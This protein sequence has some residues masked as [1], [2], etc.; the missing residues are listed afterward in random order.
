MAYADHATGEKPLET[1]IDFDPEKF[2]PVWDTAARKMLNL[3]IDT[4][5]STLYAD[6]FDLPTEIIL[7]CAIGRSL[8]KA[9]AETDMSAAEWHWGFHF[10][11][12]PVAEAR[13]YASENAKI[14]IASTAHWRTS[15]A[16]EYGKFL[17]ADIG[18][19][20]VTPIE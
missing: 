2:K 20:T 11:D 15:D 10:D 14:R 8:I 3:D 4:I 16:G 18:D 19:F 9:F 5:P 7:R 6:V 13:L 1:V 17:S 12:L